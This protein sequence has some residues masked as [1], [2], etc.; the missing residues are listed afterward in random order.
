MD[1]TTHQEEVFIRHIVPNV[2]EKQFRKSDAN[3]TM[4]LPPAHA[5]A[6]VHTAKWKDV[7][8][9]EIADGKRQPPSNDRQEGRI[10]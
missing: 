2:C 3:R 8:N 5:V 1:Q 10:K 7:I 6:C 4:V 9:H